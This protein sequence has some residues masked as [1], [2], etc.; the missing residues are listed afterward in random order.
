M[1]PFQA[2]YKINLSF[3]R[4]LDFKSPILHLNYESLKEIN[5]K[6][7][8]EAINNSTSNVFDQKYLEKYFVKKD[9]DEEKLIFLNF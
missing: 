5:S 1:H 6:E 3:D 2:D 7:S 4:I 9:L 8:I